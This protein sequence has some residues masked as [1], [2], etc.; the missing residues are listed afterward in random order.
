M[1]KVFSLEDWKKHR[2]SFGDC[3]PAGSLVR[4]DIFDYFLNVLPPVYWQRGIMQCSEP[5][6]HRQ[7]DQGRFR[8]TFTTF[9]RVE[10]G[11]Y[12]YC[13]HCFIGETTNRD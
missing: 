11:L 5:Y 8:A 2:G 9:Q 7:D 13:G 10:D 3:V 12:R 4:E 6:S 1:D